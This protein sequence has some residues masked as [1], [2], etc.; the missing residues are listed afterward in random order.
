MN[1]KGNFIKTFQ[2]H[3]FKSFKHW[4]DFLNYIQMKLPKYFAYVY[5]EDTWG[6]FNNLLNF[7]LYDELNS[8]P[9]EFS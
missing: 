2:N 5:D 4:P 7:F 9:H 6:I 3:N 1:F 8:Q